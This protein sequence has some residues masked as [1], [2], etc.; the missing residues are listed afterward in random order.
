M[1]RIPLLS[2]INL[3]AAL[4]QAP[5]ASNT[6][7]GAP[8]ASSA[9]GTTATAA[10]IPQ[11]AAAGSVPRAGDAPAMP[12]PAFLAQWRML[13]L[14]PDAG[15]LARHTHLPFQFQGR[16]L[17]RDG[18]IREAVP[19]LFD[20]ATRSCIERGVPQREGERWTLWCRPYGF[21]FAQRDGR[22]GLLEFGTDPER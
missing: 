10:V 5:A 15:G 8:I 9:R 3:V 13:A 4:A 17:D 7:S 11:A 20:R 14:R 16:A 22:W 2:L 19:A 1:K 18:F 21:V 12:L 6:A